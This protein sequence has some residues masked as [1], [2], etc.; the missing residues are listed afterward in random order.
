MSSTDQ[1]DTPHQVISQRGTHHDHA[2]VSETV[3]G[4]VSM[5]KREQISVYGVSHPLIKPSVRRKSRHRPDIQVSSARTISHLSPHCTRT[6]VHVHKSLH[7]SLQP[8]FPAMS[9]RKFPSPRSDIPAD[10]AVPTGV[11]S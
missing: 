4:Y 11:V 1:E 10:F 2:G 8:N 3:N 6:Q 9:A 5:V 7:K